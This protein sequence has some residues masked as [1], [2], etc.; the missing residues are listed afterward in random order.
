[1]KY[2]IHKTELRTEGQKTVVL[3]DKIET[4]NLEATRKELHRQYPCDKVLF[5]YEKM[6]GNTESK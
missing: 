2:I 3:R 6:Y 4:T 5:H 1:M